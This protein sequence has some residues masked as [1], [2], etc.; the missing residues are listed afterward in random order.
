MS[1][2]R[3]YFVAAAVSAAVLFCCRPAFAAD[4]ETSG[5]INYTSTTSDL[6]ALLGE[7]PAG[8]FSWAHNGNVNMYAGD[9]IT[10]LA[11]VPNG[12]P[13]YLELK[14]ATVSVSGKFNVA[15]AGKVN[16]VDVGGSGELVLDNTTMTVGG[17]FDV[18][19]GNALGD[20]VLN[21]IVG[22]VTLRNG[23]HLTVGGQVQLSANAGKSGEWNAQVTNVLVLSSGSVLT[24]RD[25]LSR[26]DGPSGMVVFDGGMLEK[27]ADVN[28]EFF[29][30]NG[31]GYDGKSTMLITNT[32]GNDV[33]LKNSQT[34]KLFNAQNTCYFLVDGAIRKLGRGVMVFNGPSG[35]NGDHKNSLAFNGLSIEEGAVKLFNVFTFLDPVQYPADRRGTISIAAGAR[36]DLNNNDAFIED[37]TGEGTILASYSTGA[38]LTLC[39]EVDSNPLTDKVRVSAGITTLEKRGNSVTQVAALGADLGTTSVLAGTLRIVEP[40]FGVPAFTHYRFRVTKVNDE[41]NAD[42]IMEL[43]EIKLIEGDADVTFAA[44]YKWD[45]TTTKTG[46]T[47]MFGNG[48][49]P[50]KAYDMNLT[51][52]WCDLRLAAQDCWWIEFIYDAPVQVTAYNWAKTDNQYRS[53]RAWVLEGSDDGE[54]WT[55]VDSR[56]MDTADLPKDAWVSAEPFAVASAAK[57]RVEKLGALS[58]A[59]GATLDLSAL[60]CD[61]EVSSISGGGTIAL[62][63]G[64]F[65][66]NND[67][68]TVIDTAQ[69][70]GS[71]SAIVKKGTGTL[72]V[73]GALPAPLDVRDGEVAPAAGTIGFPGKYF[74]FTIKAT[75][76]KQQVG[77]LGKFNL[78]AAD[79]TAVATGLKWYGAD[80]LP[81][82]MYVNDK[83]GTP[84]KN[85]PAGTFSQGGQYTY[86]YWNGVHEMPA[87]IFYAPDNTANKWC[88]IQHE[89]D[90]N[91]EST[92]Y[93]LN[94]RLADDAPNV[95]GYNLKTS[96][97]DNNDRPVAAWT[98]KGSLDGETWTL[99]DERNLGNDAPNK[100]NTWYNNGTPSTARGESFPIGD[101]QAA[102]SADDVPP[103]GSLVVDLAGTSGTLA[104]FKPAAN[105][106][107]VILNAPE[108]TNFSNWTVPLS[109]GEFSTDASSSLRSWSI[110]VDGV[111]LGRYRLA[112]SGGDLMVEKKSGFS[113][114]VR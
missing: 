18:S 72:S 6:A 113:V 31:Y 73:Y 76:T 65:V 81:G 50:D 64:A 58:V 49:T 54:T 7:T 47:D 99:L 16:G 53:P 40:A 112:V 1:M 56:E 19:C 82:W 90:V 52:K 77:E 29:N 2:R 12:T 105:G 98:L 86:S 37:L 100:G 88:T 55:I 46:G 32:P 75:R 63:S 11:N 42:Q 70:T 59:S 80:N 22:R 45:S 92:W 28:N 17:F 111:A 114:F 25:Q 60:D 69:F 104:R 26:W 62:G 51:S 103:I 35:N 36:L 34:N 8:A 9:L 83:D 21:P 106:T 87:C 48:E 79:G 30:P 57:S 33:V 15:A 13:A 102:I 110:V 95:V 78:F 20:K 66:V 96:N 97:G 108:G 44:S 24:T 5:T 84:A 41:N 38:A 94:M 85:L 71:P 67:G 4:Y 10:S 107:L 43:R 91:D 23:S 89:F 3:K 39:N 101:T 61:V 74:Q 68:D 14:D 109:V 27:A 93:V